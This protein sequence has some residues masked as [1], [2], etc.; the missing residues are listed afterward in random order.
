MQLSQEDIDYFKRGTAENPKFWSRFDNPSMTGKS[1]L[2][3]GC[4]HGSLCID[5][6]LAGADRVVG[7]DLDS[8]RVAFAQANLEQNYPQLRER[9]TFVDIALEDYPL[10]GFDAIVS[11]DSF[12]HIID[13]DGVLAEMKRRL[14][15]GGR[16]YSGFGPLYNSMYGGHGRIHN[17]TYHIPW[18][19]VI[20]PDVLLLKLVNRHRDEHVYS[21][22]DLGLNKLAL[23]DYRRIIYGAGLN[24]VMF[25]VNHSKNKI[26][27]L[28][29]LLRTFPFLEEYFSHNIYCIL[30]RPAT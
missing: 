6:A 4:G 13:L 26:S 25:E 14:A 3:V 12:E 23:H 22:H 5:A 19:H 17:Y 20:L 11:K 8:E 27:Q 28:F 21:I 7:I 18:L 10:E 29:S 9:V 1:L 24:V 16:I 30:E 15:P 2:D